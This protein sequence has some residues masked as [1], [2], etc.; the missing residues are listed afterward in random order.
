MTS[1]YTAQKHCTHKINSVRGNMDTR[2]N[3]V[4]LIER[5]KKKGED[6]WSKTKDTKGADQDRTGDLQPARQP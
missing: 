1:R 3:K 6:N 4:G 5:K 2:G